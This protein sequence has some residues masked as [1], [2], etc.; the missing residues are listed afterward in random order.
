MVPAIAISGWE[1]MVPAGQAMEDEGRFQT[2]VFAPKVEHERPIY[3]APRILV[4]ARRAEHRLAQRRSAKQV[5]KVVA[6]PKPRATVA[7]VPMPAPRRPITF[8]LASLPPKVG[9]DPVA[10][11]DAPPPAAP[12]PVQAEESKAPAPQVEKEPQ[13]PRIDP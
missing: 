6:P 1:Q 7:T 10:T 12:S 3:R 5:A 4:R 8:Q 11:D 13:A 2:R 9:L